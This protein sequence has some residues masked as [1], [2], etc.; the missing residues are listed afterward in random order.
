MA[1]KV[2]DYSGLRVGTVKTLQSVGKPKNKIISLGVG[3]AFAALS[4]F[5]F[6]QQLQIA[7][8]WFYIIPSISILMA[9]KELFG[10]LFTLKPGLLLLLKKPKRPVADCYNNPF[11][12]E[13]G[14]LS[15]IKLDGALLDFARPLFYSLICFSNA[16]AIFTYALQARY[17]MNSSFFNQEILLQKLGNIMVIAFDLIVKTHDETPEL[18]MWLFFKL[19]QNVALLIFSHF[20][21][22]SSMYNINDFLMD[23]AEGKVTKEEAKLG[24]EY[25]YSLS[26][27]QQALPDFNKYVFGVEKRQIKDKS[28]EK[29]KE[30]EDTKEKENKNNDIKPKN[31]DGIV[32]RK[33]KSDL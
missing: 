8:R 33:A 29:E 23:V 2:S 1:E 10:L 5:S 9:G 22:S 19:V 17:A 15:F 28:E 16:R 18:N 21:I 3:I 32:R 20:S 31:D 14:L 6:V 13:Y 30:K 24:Y 27:G 26:T 11:D 4:L 12:E 25:I 7:Y